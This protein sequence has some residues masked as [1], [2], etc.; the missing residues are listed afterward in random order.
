[1]RLP[2]VAY[3]AVCILT[4]GLSLF[5]QSPNGNINGQVVDPVN[6]AVTSADIVAVND[7]TGVQYTTK[8]NDEGLYVLPNLPPGPYRLQVSKVGFKTL[9]KP[10]IVLSV[11]DA[12]SINFTLPI[13]AFHETITVEAG[14]PLVN[15]ESAA[16][17]T[18]VDRQFVENLPLNGRSFN[19]LLQ[20]T[21]GVVMVPSTTTNPGQFSING[22]RSNANYFQVDGVSVNFGIS[23]QPVLGQQGAGGTQ[24][25]NS[26]GGTSSL[27]SV[28][29]MQEFRV[30]TSSFAPEYGHT[31]GGQVSIVTRS[32]TNNFHGDVFNYFRN[33]AL[34]ANDWFADAAGQRKPAERQNDFGGVFGGPLFRDKT[35]FFVSYEGLRLTQ[36]V[37]TVIEVPSLSARSI[38]P[39][40]AAPILNAY[41]V[42]A[43]NAVVSPDGGAARFTGSYSNT[44]SMDALSLRLDHSFRSGLTAFVRGNL[45]PSSNNNR[46][47]GLSDVQHVSVD[48][49]TLTLGLNYLITPHLG[50]SFRVNVSRQNAANTTALDNFDGAVPPPSNFLLPSSYSPNNT[51]AVFALLDNSSLEVG[52]LAHNK[53]SQVDLL[54]DVDFNLGAHALKFGVDTRTLWLNQV[55]AT[56]EPVY[57]GFSTIGF[58][59]SGAA[60]FVSTNLVRPGRVRFRELSLYA[61]DRWSLGKRLT[62]TYGGRCEMNPAPTALGSTML[63]SWQNAQDPAQTSLAPAGTPVFATTYFNIAPRVGIAYNLTSKGDLVVRGGWGIFYD[64]GTSIAPQ[65]LSQFPNASSAMFFGVPLPLTDGTAFA[66]PAPSVVPPYQSPL[67]E[68][69]VPNLKLPYSQEWNVSIE[70]ALSD[71]ESVS[72]SYVGQAGR[73]LMLIDARPQPNANFTGALDLFNN[74]GTSDYN[75]LQLQFKRRFAGRWQALANY[76]YSHSIDTSSDDT[77][78]GLSTVTWPVKNERG[79][80]DF[81]V[82]HN[83]TGA[84]S[85]TLP[86]LANTRL[87]KATTEGW[88]L[89]AMVQARSGV[90]VN[91]YTFAAAI[92]GT[93]GTRPDL[94][95]GAPIWLSDPTAG[96]GKRLNPAAFVTPPSS[97]QGTLPRNS[98]SGF[99]ATQV[100][101]SLRRRIP[102]SDKLNLDFRADVFNAFNHPNFSNPDGLVGDAQFGLSTGMLNRG[103]G[104]L[105]PLYQIGGPRSIQLSLKFSF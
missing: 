32:G 26:F 31:P 67:V 83:V 64:L 88:S 63:A 93:A 72:A 62:I 36:P 11:Q 19:T 33:D 59:T 68:G 5:A 85:A 41:P 102:F 4:F 74:G 39:P 73:H 104:G 57:V 14:S 43:A 10:D 20:L 52:S 100:D 89:D 87:L 76:T 69:F 49:R 97:R 45:A 21:P 92:P 16:V 77:F 18:V 51:Y 94:V 12:I 66:P 6:R 22:Q 101:L 103:L 61:Q 71:K 58:A 40:A 38:V 78:A 46:I 105:N 65:L 70:K 27:A 84:V 56:F 15:T 37:T 98:I 1:M 53:E 13:G 91:I 81:D 28:D 99:G 55:G 30:T 95:P 90:P 48:T 96:G 2:R 50:N 23:A 44:I 34:D 29:A 54:D 35:F 9:I 86:T 17:S 7:S 25:F 80:S 24:A 75:A 79:N 60:D 82:R 3:I 47:L 42:P 8:T